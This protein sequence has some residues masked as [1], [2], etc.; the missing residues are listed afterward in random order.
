MKK[1]SLLLI[2]V[3]GLILVACGTAQTGISANPGV[4]SAKSQPTSAQSG[5]GPD[6]LIRTDNQGAVAFTVQPTNLSSADES[7]NFAVSMN[8]HSVDLSMDLA[9]FAILTTDNGNSVQGNLWDDPRGGH[10]VSGTLT[11]PATVSGKSIPE[12]AKQLSLIIKNVD[13]PERTF[14]WDLP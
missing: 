1:L 6:D 8:T 2:L 10:H 14:T 3:L 4:A 11:F 13:A 9:T 5:S 7:L 12:G